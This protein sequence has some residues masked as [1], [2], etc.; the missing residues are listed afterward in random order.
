MRYEDIKSAPANRPTRFAMHGVPGIG[1]TTL[2][3][4]FPLPVFES[5]E[6]GFPRDLPYRPK[7]LPT[8]T[9]WEDVLEH[10]DF[11]TNEEHPFETIVYDTV[12]WLEPLLWRF[13]CERDS[14]RKT[15]LNKSGAKLISIEDYGF[16]KGYIAAE[17]EFRHFVDKLDV[18]QVKR[19]M[20]V[21]MLMHSHIKN[22]KNPTGPDFDQWKPKP[23]ALVSA[24][25]SEWAENFFFGFY[26]IAAAKLVD[27]KKAKGVGGS[28]RIL[29]TRSTAAYDAKNR[30]GLQAEVE[31]EDP[32]ALIPF[33]LGQCVVRKYEDAPAPEN[34]A[35]KL[36]PPAENEK[37]AAPA[38]GS[39]KTSPKETPSGTQTGNR[40]PRMPAEA[41]DEKAKE[42]TEKKQ[43]HEPLPVEL[44][45]KSAYHVDRQADEKRRQDEAFA[46]QR[47]RNEETEKRQRDEHAAKRAQEQQSTQGAAPSA[48]DLIEELTALITRAGDEM[49]PD[50]RKKVERWTKGAGADPEKLVA[51]IEDVTATLDR[52]AEEQ[53]Q[54]K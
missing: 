42:K 45:G 18:L 43:N 4:E 41:N 28:K 11:L 31:F 36:P 16:Q 22:F 15:E 32:R 14:G 2:A 40:A 9:K 51:I 50:Y 53:Q 5:P 10:V 48:E 44:Q 26:D 1:K 25:V 6:A 27:E 29:G 17:E 35:E 7:V 49:G 37:K 13:C 19:G 33:L 38:K 34:P 3:A 52:N 20:H 54:G 24:I 47:K 46:E 21:V 39:K 30:I 12:D 23:H 8:P